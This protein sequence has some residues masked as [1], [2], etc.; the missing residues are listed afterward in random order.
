L[1]TPF[2]LNIEKILEHW[3]VHDAIR[4]V[5]ANAIDEQQLT[6]TRDIEINQTPQGVWVIRDYGRGL[7]VGHLTQNES[8]EKLANPNMI[9]KFGIG[10]KDA[11]ATFYRHNVN[12]SIHSKFNDFTLGMSSKAG[13]ENIKTLHAMVDDHPSDP[14]MVGTRVELA[15]VTQQDVEKAKDLFLRFSGEKELDSTEAGEVL[16]KKSDHARIYINGVKVAEEE[17]FLFSYNITA[18]TGALRKALNRERTNVG[19]TAYQERVKKILISSDS[20]VV[21]E[22]LADDLREIERGNQHDELQWIDVQEHAVKILNTTGKMVFLTSQ[23]LID[24]TMMVD[25]ARLMGYKIVTVPEKLKE[26]IQGLTDVDG[27]AIVDLTRF[28][29]IYMESFKFKFIEPD[30]LTKRERAVFEKT[31]A[32]MN[33]VGGKPKQVKEIKISETM[34]PAL[35]TLVQTDGLWESGEGRI[36]IKRSALKEVEFYAGVLIHELTHAIGGAPDVSRD[37]EDGLTLMTG[38]TGAKALSL[39]GK[40]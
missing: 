34:R 36:I 11:L 25:E 2:D 4:E 26:R 16:A 17:N 35:G 40:K 21:A 29:A 28:A 31:E 39:E 19:R 23:E 32:I 13:F 3:D 12:V 20:K 37:F 33:L 38:H 18:L 30:K 1:A 15:G 24:D 6:H 7:K 5:I 8:K 10:L 27:N 9:G 22:R 14:K